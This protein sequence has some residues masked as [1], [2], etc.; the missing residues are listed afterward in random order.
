MRRSV[1]LT[2]LLL[3]GLTILAFQFAPAQAAALQPQTACDT[4]WASGSIG[5]IQANCQG[6]VTASGNWSVGGGA[7]GARVQCYVDGILR[8]EIIK[9][10]LSGTWECVMNGLPIG[11]HTFTLK[12]IPTNGGTICH[13]DTYTVSQ[14]FVVPAC[15]SAGLSCV[16]NAPPGYR[17]T[18]TAS[19]GVAPYT[20]WWGYQPSGGAIQWSQDPP[21]NGPF[22]RI[23]VCK[24]FSHFSVYF[25]V[26]DS[27][28][29][30]SNTRMWSCN[31]W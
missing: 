7:T 14:S 9:T 18:G 16:T 10:G 2:L 4:T 29:V 6:Y 17:C 26:V 25:K 23:Y 1:M 3:M 5:N 15:L 24:S 8:V 20:P 11:S 12:V 19:G 31:D 13:E 27:S 22:T 28:G 30:T 21:G